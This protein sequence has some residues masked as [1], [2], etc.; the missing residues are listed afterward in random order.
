MCYGQL[1]EREAFKEKGEERK[2]IYT[3]TTQLVGSD[4][5]SVGQVCCASGM[6]SW[7]REAALK[8]LEWREST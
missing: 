2:W 3:E 1:G 5:L 7:G 8:Q 6:G 4:G